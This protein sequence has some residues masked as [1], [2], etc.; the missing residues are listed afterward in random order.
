MSH[1]DDDGTAAI[2]ATLS[3]TAVRRSNLT[4]RAPIDPQ[5]QPI[6]QP[7]DQRSALEPAGRAWTSVAPMRVPSALQ[8]ST[9]I[10]PLSVVQITYDI[11]ASTSPLPI[12]EQSARPVEPAGVGAPIF[13]P[14]NDAIQ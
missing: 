12:S 11:E 13:L 9:V 10:R 8:R 5:E 1:G 3:V 2:P 4:S 14:S 7:G 6:A